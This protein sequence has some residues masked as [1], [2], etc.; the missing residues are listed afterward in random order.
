MVYTLG[1]DLGGTKTDIGI[2]DASGGIVRRELIKTSKAGPDA[3][4]ADILRTAKKLESKE[5][6]IQSI[7]I[8]SQDLK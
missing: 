2:V 1:I 5:M 8:G 4:V 7:G 6:P 3:V